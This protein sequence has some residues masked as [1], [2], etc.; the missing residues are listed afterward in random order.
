L[1]FIEAVFICEQQCWH[2]ISSEREFWP[3]ENGSRSGEWWALMKR[4]YW[5]FSSFLPSF[6]F[7]LSFFFCILSFSFSLFLSITF[8]SFQSLIVSSFLSLSLSRSFYFKAHHVYTSWPHYRHHHY[9]LCI[10]IYICMRTT[11]R[12]KRKRK[13][14]L[15]YHHNH[16]NIYVWISKGGEE[17][18]QD[19]LTV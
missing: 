8:V 3:N 19:L 13:K 12:E 10:Y 14:A 2:R 18:T 17:V 15:H 1:R 6:P 16:K 7:L 9:S 11:V 5:A 4:V